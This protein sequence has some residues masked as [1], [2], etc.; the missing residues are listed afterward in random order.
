MVDQAGRNT[1]QLGRTVDTLSCNMAAMQQSLV[2]LLPLPLPPSSQS[3]PPSLVLSMSPAI[4]YSFR[5]PTVSSEIP[6]HQMRWLASHSPILSWVLMGTPPLIYTVA[7]TVTPST[8]NGSSGLLAPGTGTFYDG[9][10]G[11]LLYDSGPAFLAAGTDGHRLGGVLGG[12]HVGDPV[13]L[14]AG[15]HAPP[16]FYNLEFATYDGTIDTLNWL[17]QCGQFFQGQRTLASDYTWLASYYLRGL[18]QTWYY[19]LEQDEGM[20]A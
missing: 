9:T 17:N 1:A 3:A 5:M 16:R 11:M 14:P 15:A 13:D 7:T 20:P 12:A 6:L 10:S 19:A 18:V 4:Q 2:S 8:G